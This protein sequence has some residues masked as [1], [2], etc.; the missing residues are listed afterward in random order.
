VARYG[1]AIVYTVC[2]TGIGIVFTML[3]AYALSISFWERAW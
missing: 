3:M 1:W 2:G